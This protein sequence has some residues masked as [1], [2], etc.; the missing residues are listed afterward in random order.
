M[1]KLSD[2]SYRYPS[3]DT[4]ALNEINLEIPEGQFV[5]IV[6]ANGAGKST[7]CYALSGFAPHFYRGKAQGRFELNDQDV[8]ASDLGQ[9]AGEVGLVFQNPFNQISGA[10]YTV[11]E[12]IAFGLENLGMPPADIRQRVDEIL[13]QSDLTELAERSPFALSGGQQQRVAIAAIMAMQP[14]VLVLDEPT[15]QLDPHG[16]KEVFASLDALTQQRAATVVLASHKLEWLAAFCDRVLVLNQGRVVADGEP[17][18]VLADEAL[19]GYGIGGTRYTLAA[20]A[21]QQ[22][23]LVPTNRA[24][25]VTLDQAKDFF[26]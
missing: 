16:T 15:S 7:L 14:G 6:G 22:G 13:A 4:W 24:L 2:F 8:L 9:L 3:A 25:P 1:I 10:R 19:P 23:G 17:A 21:A 11:R 5:G 20:R 12:E 18:R 26:Q